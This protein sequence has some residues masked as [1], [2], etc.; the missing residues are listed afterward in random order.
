MPIASIASIVTRPPPRYR[1]ITEAGS[2]TA[3][4]GE[5]HAEDEPV[6][7]VVQHVAEAVREDLPHGRPLAG[8]AGP[9]VAV[10]RQ[11]ALGPR[12]R[13]LA[14]LCERDIAVDGLHG[15]ILP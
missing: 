2:S 10:E 4:R 14:R 12:R 15:T 8:E 6:C 13:L 1:S 3:T 11:P 9:A 7:D 5:D